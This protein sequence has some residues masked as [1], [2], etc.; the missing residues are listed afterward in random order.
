MDT[1]ESVYPRLGEFSIRREKSNYSRMYLSTWCN[2]VL[3]NLP[4]CTLKQNVLE[5]VQS[6]ILPVSRYYFTQSMMGTR[7]FPDC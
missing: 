3:N 1:T 5:T 7:K 4:P 6:E 2:P